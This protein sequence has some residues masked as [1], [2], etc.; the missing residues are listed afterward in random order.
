MIC[1]AFSGASVLDLGSMWASGSLRLSKMISSSAFLPPP[2]A[3]T[4]SASF[5]SPVQSVTYVA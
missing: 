3:R 1:F 2:L 4:S 5:R